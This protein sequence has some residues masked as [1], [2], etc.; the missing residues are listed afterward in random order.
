MVSETKS[1]WEP[2]HILD[3]LGLVINTLLMTL[4]V[5][6]A[7]VTKAVTAAQQLL[8]AHQQHHQ[9]SARQL[10]SLAGQVVSMARAF[11]PARL[12]SHEWLH[13]ASHCRIT[14]FNDKRTRLSALALDDLR[15]LVSGL[16]SWNGKAAIKPVQAEV[17]ETDASLLGWGATWRGQWARGY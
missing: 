7:R 10:L 1:V 9:V 15:W 14:R 4:F 2:T 16:P 3:F 17:V 11:A 8:A 6:Q 5:P 12:I 13:I